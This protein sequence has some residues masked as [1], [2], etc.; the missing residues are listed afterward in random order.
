MNTPLTTV[1][2]AAGKGT[3]MKSDKAKV[4]HE[5]FNRP[6]VHYVIDALLALEPNQTIAVVGHQEE[7]VRNS[8][9]R[10]PST[11]LFRSSSLVQAMQYWLLRLFVAQKMVS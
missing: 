11:M 10:F 2:L 9:K 4:L 3:R 8:L 6:M 5:V 7:E 1:V